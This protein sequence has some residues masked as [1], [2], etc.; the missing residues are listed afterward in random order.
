MKLVSVVGARPNFMKLAPLAAEFDRRDDVEHF[1]VHTGQHYDVAMSDAFFQELQIPDPRYHLA[2]GSGT[3]AQQTAAV[4]ERIEPVL[5]SERPDMVIVYGDV[6]STVAAALTAAKLNI[7]V[8]HVEAGLRSRDRTMP[9]EINRL[10]TDALADVLLAPSP[11]AMDNLLA[12]GH[13]ADTIHFVGNIMIDVLRF[14]LKQIEGTRAASL[15]V[16]VPSKPYVVATIHRPANVD[17]PENIE[18]IMRG[19]LELSRDHTVLFP[20]HP[21]TRQRLAA[22]SRTLTSERELKLQLLDP[23]P[24]LEMTRLVAGAGL[25]ITDSG[26]LQEETTYLGV[27][28]LT[29]R[30]TTERPITCS[31]GTNRL[32]PAQRESIVTLAR[33]A[34]ARPRGAPPIIERWDGHTAERIADVLCGAREPAAS[35]S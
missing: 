34:L 26:G 10:V 15:S 30:T 8:A 6:N 13:A 31:E 33:E 35:A 22:L 9:E 24:Y 18:Q 5:M 28:C 7:P 16:N 4:V 3:H 23:V 17:D 27:P 1:V 2:V 11:D 21:R 14:A 19:L 29:V 20:V 12:E 25:V 32:I